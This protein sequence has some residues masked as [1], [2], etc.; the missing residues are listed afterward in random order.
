MASSKA[1]FMV[2]CSRISRRAASRPMTRNS[3]PLSLM[4]RGCVRSRIFWVGGFWISGVCGW[5]FAMDFLINILRYFRQTAL[6]D[7]QFANLHIIC[8]TALLHLNLVRRPAT[9][10]MIPAVLH[11]LQY[12]FGA[13]KTVEARRFVCGRHFKEFKGLE[14]LQDIIGVVLRQ[15]AFDVFREFA[16]VE[17]RI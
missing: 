9:H 11:S 12:P 7:E 17:A 13:I 8:Q 15:N 5:L 4:E 1:T 10:H 2:G 16:V 6:R 14:L 3:A